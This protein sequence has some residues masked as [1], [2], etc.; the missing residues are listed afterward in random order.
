MAT[1]ATL[2]GMAFSNTFTAACH[3]L[4][5]PIGAEFSLSHGASCAITLDAVAELNAPRVAEKFH[6]LHL[7]LQLPTEQTVPG[8]IRKMRLDVGTIPNL[9]AL[10]S[11]PDQLAKI[12]AGVFQPLMNNNPIVLG[13]DELIRFLRTVD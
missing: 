1:A 5:Y 9:K 8:F 3:A 12:A 6:D 2:A 7:Q 10:V 4:S 11:S 13:S